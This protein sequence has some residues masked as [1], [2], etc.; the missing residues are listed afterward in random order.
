MKTTEINLKRCGT[1][2]AAIAILVGF[3]WLRF[4]DIIASA[5][6][7]NT[8]T[9]V[10]VSYYTGMPSTDISYNDAYLNGDTGVQ[11]VSYTTKSLGRLQW[12]EPDGNG[13]YDVYYDAADVHSLAAHLNESQEQYNELYNTYLE[14]KSAVLE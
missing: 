2:A 6:A 1:I 13:E 8:N 9:Q 5:V 10:T 7:T 11:K 4:G 14:L 3:V 12:G